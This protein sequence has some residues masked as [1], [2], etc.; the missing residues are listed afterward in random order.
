MGVKIGAFGYG[1]GA[2]FAAG[3]VLL[4]IMGNSNW[5]IFMILAFVIWFI[6][7]LPR[8]ARM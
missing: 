6:S 8:L 4:A 2:I 7:A 3:A 1:I 5:F